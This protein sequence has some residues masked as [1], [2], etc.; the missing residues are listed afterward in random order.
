MARTLIKSGKVI[1]PAG[2]EPADVLIDGETIASVGLPGSF[3]DGETGYDRVVDAA[4]KYVLPGGIDVHTHMELPFGGTFASDTFETGTRA[5]AWGGVTTIV[6]FAVQRTG[7]DVQA[8]LAE[9]HRKAEGECAIDYGFHQ[10]IGGV[11]D[12]ALKSIRYLTEHEGVTSFKLFMA[13]PGVLYSDDGQILRAMQTAGEC[14]AMIM[15][16]AENGIAIDVLVA[17]ALARGD[18]DPVHHG[19]TRPSELEA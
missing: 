18:T 14:G 19:Y 7:E 5:A 15:M 4:G 17:Q 13:Y 10:I 12:E 1:S 11:D 8:G 2:V 3:A 6:D 9:W 16:H